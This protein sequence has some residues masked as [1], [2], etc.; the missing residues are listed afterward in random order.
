MHIKYIGPYILRHSGHGPTKVQVFCHV[1]RNS[2][3]GL[4]SS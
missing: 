2:A 3:A 4:A 1:Q